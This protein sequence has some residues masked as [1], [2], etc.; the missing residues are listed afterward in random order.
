MHT[1][2]FSQDHRHTCIN[3]QSH[4]YTHSFLYFLLLIIHTECHSLITLV[5]TEASSI[6][7][8]FHGIKWHEKKAVNTSWFNNSE[9]AGE[10][11]EA[12]RIKMVLCSASFGC[13]IMRDLHSEHLTPKRIKIVSDLFHNLAGPLAAYMLITPCRVVWVEDIC[14]VRWVCV[15]F[16]AINNELPQLAGAKLQH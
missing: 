15:V 13:P 10:Y 12:I 11:I 16:S 7:A 8:H 5:F 1:D 3:L 4:T 2:G 9:C 14:G 6:P